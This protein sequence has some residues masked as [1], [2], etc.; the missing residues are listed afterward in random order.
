[1]VS[2]TP[3]VQDH[4][5]YGAVRNVAD[6]HMFSG[7]PND[8]ATVSEEILPLLVLDQMDVRD[9]RGDDLSLGK[10]LHHPHGPNAPV[11][12]KLRKRHEYFGS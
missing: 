5:T 6:A 9:E 10:A 3:R 11:A 1:M 2:L 7:V 8:P 12:R 4:L